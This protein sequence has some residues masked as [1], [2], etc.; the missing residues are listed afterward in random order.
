MQEDNKIRVV[1]ENRGHEDE[2]FMYLVMHTTFS[3]REG[4]KSFNLHS[5]MYT[6]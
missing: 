4:E 1:I 5:T 3:I 6:K 2:N